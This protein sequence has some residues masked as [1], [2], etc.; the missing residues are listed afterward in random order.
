MILSIIA[1]LTGCILTLAQMAL[2][3]YRGDGICFNAGCEIVDNLTLVPPFY[4]NFAGFL[5]FLF[6]SISLSGARK[7][8]EEWERFAGLLLLAGTAAEGVLF[9]FQLF[10]TEAFCSYCLIIFALVV[11]ANLFMG[12]KQI[13][14]AGVIF[15]S[16][17]IG[18]ASLDFRVR[19]QDEYMSLDSGSIA[20]LEVDS[21]KR[22]LY[23]LFSSTCIH[24]EKVI[25]EMKQGISCSVNF[26]P[27][28]QFDDFKFPGAE[29]S[30]SYSTQAN[31]NF[32]RS[33][34]LNGVPVLVDKHGGTTTIWTGERTIRTFLE[35]NCSVENKEI[36]EEPIGQTQAP[37]LNLPSKDEDCTINEDCGTQTSIP[38][39]PDQQTTIN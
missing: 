4:F 27:L 32:L 22:T 10:I 37:T 18:F 33:L 28:D 36:P 11:T 5:F 9:S 20:R 21:S 23:L 15:I 39:S 12:V 14:K 3:L 8:S 2:I 38:T 30:N 13:F 34:G 1:S 26:N 19:Q 31:L 16:I 7:G 24:C 17:L 25:E 6:V 29:S 35:L